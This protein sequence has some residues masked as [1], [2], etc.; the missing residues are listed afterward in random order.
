[1]AGIT[2]YE[3]VKMSKK[4][5]DSLGGLP[6]ALPLPPEWHKPDFPYFREIR[7]TRINETNPEVVRSDIYVKKRSDGKVLGKSVTFSRRGGDIPTGL[8]HTSSFGCAEKGLGLTKEIFDV[9]GG[10]K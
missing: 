10:A 5:Y 7:E 4:E 9:Q 8:F 1:V 6:G 3:R 2:V